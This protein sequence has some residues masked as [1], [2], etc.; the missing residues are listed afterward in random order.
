M[1]EKPVYTSDMVAVIS[2]TMLAELMNSYVDELEILKRYRDL[3]ERMEEDMKSGDVRLIAPVL[4]DGEFSEFL[5]VRKDAVHY[6]SKLL[7][8]LDSRR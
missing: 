7:Y 1:T 2:S 6:S 4:A 3:V 8:V 5:V